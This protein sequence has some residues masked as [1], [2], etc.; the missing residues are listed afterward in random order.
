M[1]VELKSNCS[2]NNQDD[3]GQTTSD[4][5]QHDC[6]S[7]LCCFCMWPPPS[8]YKSSCPPIVGGGSG[9]SRPLDR[10]LPSP[11]F[12]ASL[13]NKANCPFHSLAS[14]IAFERWAAGP[15][16]GNSIS[17][18]KQWQPQP[19]SPPGLTVVGGRTEIVGQVLE[20]KWWAG[21]TI[22][23][24][25][26]PQGQG[27]HQQP[28]SAPL[29]GWEADTSSEV[30]WG[31]SLVAQ[32]LRLYASNAG[33]LGSSPGKGSRYHMPQLWVCMPQRKIR[34][35]STQTQCSQ[36]NKYLKQ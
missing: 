7:W 34:G 1:T 12:L 4:P 14:L 33:G 32:W 30:C 10:D 20:G 13:K 9:E 27:L 22:R 23:C 15:G 35:A 18:W 31:T 5:F 25:L 3:V 26:Q 29:L 28:T 19:P 36:I 11:A 2:Q 8:V 21:E 24:S 17:T 6:Q 16:I